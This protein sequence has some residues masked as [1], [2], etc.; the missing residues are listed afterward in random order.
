MRV[1]VLIVAMLVASVQTTFGQDA[2]PRR[3]PATALKEAVRL[4]ESKKHEEFLQKFVS[5]SELETGIKKL[6]SLK[7]IVVEFNRTGRFELALKALQAA[8]K[9]QPTFYNE[10]AKANYRFDAPID[11]EVRLQLTKINGLWYWTD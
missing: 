3:E 11:G 7:D 8:M 1:I 9:V 4:L 2:D 5:P 10:G 6:G